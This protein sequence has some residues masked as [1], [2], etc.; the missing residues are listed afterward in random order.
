MAHSFVLIH[1]PLV[2]PSTWSWVADELRHRGHRA[3]VPSIVAGAQSGS[4]RSCVDVV[5]REV[6]TVGRTVLVGHSGAGPL[7]P[8]IAAGMEEPLS[9]VVFVDAGMP[10]PRGAT[11]LMPEAFAAHLKG[12]AHDGVLPPW[13]E[14]FGPGTLEG[15]VPDAAQ[16]NA[17]VTDLPTLPL[18]Y[19]D[20]TVPVPDGWSAIDGTYILLSEIYRT[21]A[22]A[23][24]ARGWPV[25]EMLGGHLDLVTRPTELADAL[26]TAVRH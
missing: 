2:G 10:P 1:S 9:R 3:F 13:S 20:G 5:L 21:D 8:P 22:N 16:R 12:L 23:A 15:L 24:A 6:P 19:F 14:W 18:A 7:L 11:E 26:E 4:W 25:I 17:V